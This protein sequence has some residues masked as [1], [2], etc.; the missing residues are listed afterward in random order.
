MIY[1]IY[2]A[3]TKVDAD[4]AFDVFIEKFEAKYFK[5]VNCMRKHRDRLLEFYNYPAEHWHSIRSTNVIESVFAT[6]RLRTY[7]TKGCG[8]RIA[9]LTMVFKLIQSA[10][11]QWIKIRFPKKIKQVWEGIVFEDG[12][13][14]QKSKMLKSVNA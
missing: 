9:T 4:I 3:P 14:V 13:A 1:N 5:A 2:L 8:S 12:I 6:V 11:K 10:Q 7:R